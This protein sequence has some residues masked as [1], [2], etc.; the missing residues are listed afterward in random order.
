[1]MKKRK[2]IAELID[3]IRKTGAEA[4]PKD[5]N[6]AFEPGASG[7]HLARLGE[8]FLARLNIPEGMDEREA[9]ERIIAMWDEADAYRNSSE[10][11]GEGE[12]DEIDE[13]DE[14][15]ESAPEF[16][17]K[18]RLP[19]PIRGG[20]FEAPKAD[21]ESMSAEQ[22]RRLKKQLERANMDGRK[23]RL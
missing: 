19:A 11:G 23:I 8:A 6:G 7:A 17:V 2:S 4:E 1:M 22:F 10:D 21:Y 12:N 18:R 3:G 20:L 13:I 16:A 14:I 5:G 15:G 9:A